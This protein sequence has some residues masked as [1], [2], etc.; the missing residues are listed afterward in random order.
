[1]GAT[2]WV[3]R[4]LGQLVV[5]AEMTSAGKFLKSKAE[6][7]LRDQPLDD[8]SNLWGYQGRPASRYGIHAA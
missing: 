5:V 1:M 8:A 2:S 7:V 4:W 6:R 3:K